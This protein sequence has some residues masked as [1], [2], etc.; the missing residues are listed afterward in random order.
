[1]KNILIET[2]ITTGWVPI[3][4]GLETGKLLLSPKKGISEIDENG[5][6]AYCKQDGAFVINVDNG[7]TLG[8]TGGVPV[9][10]SDVVEGYDAITM[11]VRNSGGHD[12]SIS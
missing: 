12:A 11:M 4:K 1:M 2:L 3:F 5:M 10:Y 8:F 9:T 7:R 6:D